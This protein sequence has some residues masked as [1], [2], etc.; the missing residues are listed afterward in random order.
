MSELDFEQVFKAATDFEPFGYQCRLACGDGA[1][2][3]KVENLRCGNICQ[4]KLINIPTGLGKT[5]AVILAWLWNRVVIPDET[6]RE[7]W[8]RRL[9]Y[10]LP[11]R[12][13]V[14]QTRDEASKWLDR[15]SLLWDGKGDHANR[16]GL[17]IL[18]GGEGEDGLGYLS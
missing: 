5:G 1:D 3:E 10:C 18:M 16:V 14:E 17:H 6:H 15:F 4:S 8:P 13:L 7:K 2:P 9:V 11:M 12:T